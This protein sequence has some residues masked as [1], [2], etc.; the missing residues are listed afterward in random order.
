MSKT[1][2]FVENNEP[3]KSPMLSDIHDSLSNLNGSECTLLELTYV[4]KGT[5]MAIGGNDERVMVTFIPDN[6]EDD[7]PSVYDES[8]PLM[9]E[10]MLTFE[11]EETTYPASFAI[12]KKLALNAFEHFLDKGELSPKL[13][14][15]I[16]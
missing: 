5:L 6:P 15:K 9:D 2:L 16:L 3:L 12:S 13:T 1:Y 11:G 4:E 14:W 7:S 8:L 10:I